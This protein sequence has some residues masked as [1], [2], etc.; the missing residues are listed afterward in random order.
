MSTSSLLNTSGTNP[1]S[2]SQWGFQA[3]KSTEIGPL[4][5]VHS[6]L[7]ILDQG[8]EVRAVFFDLRKA[9]DSVPHAILMAKLQQIGLNDHIL[10]WIGDYLTGREQRVT[11]S[12]STSQYSVVL[13]GVPQGFVLGP[14]LFFIYVD[15]LACIPLSASSEAVLYAD[16]LLLFRPIHGMEDFHYLQYDISAIEG[17]VSSN[18]LTLNSAKCKY[19]IVSRKANPSSPAGLSL[20]NFNLEKVE[21][22][23]YLGLLLS[24]N[25]TV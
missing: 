12:G 5:T 7:N 24:S 25:L 9:F 23:K 22:F 2:D 14:L 3:G 1:L 8:Q 6:W 16:D 20:G 18:F 21:C 17:W 15:D 19:M 13:S 11:V 10:A 4:V